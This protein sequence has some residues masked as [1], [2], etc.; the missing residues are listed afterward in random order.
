MPRCTACDAPDR[1]AL[2]RSLAIGAEAVS[3]L[4]RRHKLSRQAILRHRDAHLPL[5]LT[6][7]VAL[8][9]EDRGGA[10][11][12]EIDGLKDRVSGLLN[13]AE[14]KG[15]LRG[16]VTAIREGARLLELIAKLRGDLTPP[17]AV[18]I[19]VVQTAE[20]QN[21]ASRILAALDGYPAARAAV[22][23]ALA[24]GAR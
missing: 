16:A 6:E 11:I 13:R 23:A 10:L 3:T 4:A 9:T 20:F 5:A 21:V 2:D 8:A 19:S 17:P 14:Q 7:A 18:T 15:D 1:A 12:A 24:A 22:V